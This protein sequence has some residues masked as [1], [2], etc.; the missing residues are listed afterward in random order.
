MLDTVLNVLYAS[1]HLILTATRIWKIFLH[2]S[3][4]EAEAGMGVEAST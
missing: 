2:F 3:D 4:E 1:F